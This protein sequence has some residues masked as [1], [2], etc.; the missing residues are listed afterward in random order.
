MSLGVFEMNLCEF[1]GE[2]DLKK[3]YIETNVSKNI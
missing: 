2:K 1:D 3:R